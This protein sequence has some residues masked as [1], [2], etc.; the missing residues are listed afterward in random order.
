METLIWHEWPLPWVG[1]MVAKGTGGVEEGRGEQPGDGGEQ[2]GDG[3]GHRA[4]N[5]VGSD[6]Y[7]KDTPRSTLEACGYQ[8]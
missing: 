2:P 4:T 7:K 1:G 6:M 5:G 3:R 8:K